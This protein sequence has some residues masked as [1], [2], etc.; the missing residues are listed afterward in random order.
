MQWTNQK[1]EEAA[2]V[3]KVRNELD[4]IWIEGIR[5]TFISCKMGGGF[6]DAGFFNGQK[7]R[8]EDVNQPLYELE[9]ITRSI[10][11]YL[12]KFLIVCQMGEYLKDNLEA[13][14]RVFGIELFTFEHLDKIADEIEKR[15]TKR[16]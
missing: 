16:A 13:R 10:G 14:A 3:L 5:P 12:S 15:L 8:E 4:V 2:K 11:L 1:I 9:A 7:P 6:I